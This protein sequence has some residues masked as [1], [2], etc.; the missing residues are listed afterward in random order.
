MSGTGWRGHGIGRALLYDA[1]QALRGRPLV[2]DAGGHRRHG[3]SWSTGL[4]AGQGFRRIGTL[5]AVGFKFGHWVDSV[6]MQQP[7]RGGT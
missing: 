3:G 2:S 5:D 6:L 4:H 7:L 1:D